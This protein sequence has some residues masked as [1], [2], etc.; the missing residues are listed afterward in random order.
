MPRAGGRKGDLSRFWDA[1]QPSLTKEGAAGLIGA[2]R[3][4]LD[5]CCGDASAVID[6]DLVVACDG[7]VR[8][9]DARVL[10]GDADFGAMGCVRDAAR[11]WQLD[12]PDEPERG[13]HAVLSCGAGKRRPR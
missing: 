9:V 13:I 2:R 10:V 6:L 1:L 11:A 3:G 4:E 12:L 8:D 7:A 5:R